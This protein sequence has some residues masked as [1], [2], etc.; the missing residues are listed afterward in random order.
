TDVNGVSQLQGNTYHVQKNE[1]GS[2]APFNICTHG[3]LDFTISNSQ[4]NN[5]TSGAPGAYPSLYKG[6]HWGYCTPSSGLPL[7]SSAVAAGGRVT[8]SDNTTTVS[9]GAWDDAYD[10]W[11]NTASSTTNNSAGGLEMMIW[12]NHFGPIQPAGGVKV[13]SII[14]DGLDWKVWYG[15]PGSNG[16]T[17][18]YVLNSPQNTV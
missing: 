15:G 8:T 6:C 2:T 18:S 16:G 9:S 7:Q 1:W 12:L 17:V 4:I 10:I 3:G 13:S 14:I 11:W 5:S